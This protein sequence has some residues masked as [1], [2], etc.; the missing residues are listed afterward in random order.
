[1][2]NAEFLKQKALARKTMK[3]LAKIMPGAFD[4]NGRALVATLTMYPPIK[5]GRKKSA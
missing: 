2:T 4:K 5:K 1:M 3:Q